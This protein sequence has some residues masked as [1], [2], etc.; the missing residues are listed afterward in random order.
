MVEVWPSCCN[1]P[2]SRVSKISTDSG[3]QLLTP[4]LGT[5]DYNDDSSRKRIR[6][7]KVGLT[8]ADRCFIQLWSPYPRLHLECG[9]TF[10]AWL[11]EKANCLRDLEFVRKVCP[12]R[13]P[14]EVKFL[15][16]TSFCG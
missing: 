10:R 5:P 3:K 1:V 7:Q 15:V 9:L 2:V 16:L 4:L 6:A 12:R 11:V 13:A 14:L 8:H